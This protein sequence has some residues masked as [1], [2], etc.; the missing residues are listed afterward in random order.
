MNE[1][2]EE[3]RGFNYYEGIDRFILDWDKCFFDG[4]YAMIAARNEM[5]TCFYDELRPLARGP[6]D[7][8]PQESHLIYLRLENRFGVVKCC[9]VLGAFTFNDAAGWLWNAIAAPSCM[10]QDMMLPVNMTA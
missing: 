6:K 7:A 3:I 8:Y 4:E 5:P 2:I 10:P 1:P 9:F